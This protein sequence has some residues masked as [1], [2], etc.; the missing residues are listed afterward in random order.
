MAKKNKG[1]GQDEASAGPQAK[2]KAKAYEKELQKLHVELVKLAAMGG[3]QG[4][5]G[6]HRFRGS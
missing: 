4:P 3:R 2:L 1:Q 5:Q 6:L